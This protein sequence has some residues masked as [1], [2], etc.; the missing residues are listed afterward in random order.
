MRVFLFDIDGTLIATDK[1]GQHAMEGSFAAPANVSTAGPTAQ[2]RPPRG[3]SPVP[4]AGRTDRSI[5]ADHLRRA[6]LEDSHENFLRFAERFLSRLPAALASRRGR[7]LPGVIDTLERLAGLPDAC[8]GLLTGN[9]RRA[10]R[11]KLTHFGLDRYFYVQGEPLGAFGDDHHDRD[12]VAREAL[13][14]VRRRVRA[15]ID[16]EQIWIV[17]DTPR[18]VRCGRAIGARVLAVATGGYSL[19]ELRAARPDVM[20]TDLADAG[21]WWHMVHPER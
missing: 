13:A 17:G 15:D 8:V 21:V 12:D 3:K 20:V 4:Y 2:P 6:G 1:A 19:A 10:A 18:D 14:D 5:V 11:I 16:P 7:V 9:L